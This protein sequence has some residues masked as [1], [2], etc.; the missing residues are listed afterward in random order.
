MQKLI[1]ILGMS[2][3]PN[4]PQI[5][6]SSSFFHTFPGLIYKHFHM[7]LQ[8][9]NGQQFVQMKYEINVKDL[10]LFF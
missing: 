1:P 6:S 5:I 10:Y 2:K 7:Q 3:Q 9:S 8:S 4:Q